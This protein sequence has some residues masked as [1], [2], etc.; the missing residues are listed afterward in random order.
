MFPAIQQGVG[1]Y[2]RELREYK[3][4]VDGLKKVY[5]NLSAGEAMGKLGNSDWKTLTE[6]NRI[7][8]GMEKVLG[9]T[10]DEAKEIAKEIGL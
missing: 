1:V 3:E 4:F 2:K 10:K 6:W 9:L 8:S 5:G 7:I